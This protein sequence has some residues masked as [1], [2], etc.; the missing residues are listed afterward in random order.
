MACCI[1]DFG[2]KTVYFIQKEDGS[3]VA[4]CACRATNA[5]VEVPITSGQ[6]DELLSR[7]D[8]GGRRI[9]DILPDLPHQLREIFVTGTTPAEWDY[10][11]RGRL[12][13]KRAYLRFGYV[14]HQSLLSGY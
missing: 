13:P 7:P 3:W 6:A 5:D 2:G 14:Y 12:R 11:M 9:Q 8:V 10:M 4:S 1:K